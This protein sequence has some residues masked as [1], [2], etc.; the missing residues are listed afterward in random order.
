MDF[1]IRRMLRVLFVFWA[2]SITA[3]AQTGTSSIT[4]TVTDA[5]GGA[6][7]GVDI[8]L[9]N[10]ETGGRLTTVTNETGLYRFGSLAPGTYRIEAM[11]PSFTPL[12]RGPLTL[13]V[14]QTLPIDLMLQVGKVDET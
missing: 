14:S 8:T 7:P 4:G 11:L 6:L 10:E 12:S 13:Q 3:F 5:S 2:I 9:I 1:T